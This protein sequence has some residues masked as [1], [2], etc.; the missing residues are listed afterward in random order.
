M[1]RKI[2]IQISKRKLK[3]ISLQ[4]KKKIDNDK[5]VFVLLNYSNDYALYE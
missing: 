5:R 2:L 3:Q 1:L 4:K